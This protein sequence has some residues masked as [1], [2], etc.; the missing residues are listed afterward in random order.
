MASA[1][2]TDFVDLAG[3]RDESEESDHLAYRE[4]T[5]AEAFAVI[6]NHQANSADR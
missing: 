6:A 4:T 2:R 1:G 3:Y 5:L